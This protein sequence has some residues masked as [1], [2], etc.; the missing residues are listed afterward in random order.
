MEIKCSNDLIVRGGI[1]SQ[2]NKKKGSKMERT[3]ELVKKNKATGEEYIV[4]VSALYAVDIVKTRSNFSYPEG[5]TEEK[6]IEIANKVRTELES[7]P[8][9][10][11]TR[12]HY[13]RRHLEAMDISKLNRVYEIYYSER[14]E[15][16]EKSRIIEQIL[17][18]QYEL[19]DSSEILKAKTLSEEDE[20][21]PDKKLKF[22]VGEY[23]QQIGDVTVPKLMKLN[24]DQ[25]WA[26]AEFVKADVK[27]GSTK[28]EIAT[29]IHK[30]YSTPIG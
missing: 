19:K 7:N 3:I 18:R 26:V 23:L 11:V 4:P 24:T 22:N 20:E 29:E 9:V 21:Q 17:L 15:T 1:A 10:L 16:L 13:T 14:P 30:A 6:A 28:N 25:L 27:V 5:M 8:R 12:K 2:F